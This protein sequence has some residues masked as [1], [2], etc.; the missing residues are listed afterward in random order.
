MENNY[1]SESPGKG[2]N[3]VLS[4]KLNPALVMTPEN[5]VN[6]FDLAITSCTDTWNM[7]SEDCS[8]M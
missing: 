3:L 1:S 2:S 7:L 5:P 8:E 6:P 4:M